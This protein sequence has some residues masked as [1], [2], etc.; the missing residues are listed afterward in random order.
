MLT[1]ILDSNDGISINYNI[2]ISVCEWSLVARYYIDVLASVLIA[3][4]L[5]YKYSGEVFLAKL[6]T[7]PGQESVSTGL[8]YWADLWPMSTRD[9]TFPPTQNHPVKPYKLSVRLG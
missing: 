8:D 3:S 5:V 6:N 9:Y 7:V 2:S 1:V 4:S